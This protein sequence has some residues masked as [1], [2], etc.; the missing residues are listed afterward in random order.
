MRT[1]STPTPVAIL[2]MTACGVLAPPAVV[3]AAPQQA[4]P[5]TRTPAVVGQFESRR[6]LTNDSFRS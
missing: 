6:G 5:S 4:A 1:R 2:L 3:R